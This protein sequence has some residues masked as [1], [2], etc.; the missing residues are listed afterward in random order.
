VNTK[1]SATDFSLLPKNI[2][3]YEQLRDIKGYL[4]DKLITLNLTSATF[5]INDFFTEDFGNTRL[6]K[7]KLSVIRK[8][9]RKAE[10]QESYVPLLDHEA[11]IFGIRKSYNLVIN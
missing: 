6:I 5:I 3:S 7:D 10:L 11:K 9:V 8:F 1:I 2:F 4:G